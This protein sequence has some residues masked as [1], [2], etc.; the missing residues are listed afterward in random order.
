MTCP[1]CGGTFTKRLTV[2]ER[3]DVMEMYYHGGRHPRGPSQKIFPAWSPADRELF[4]MS[5]LCD[6]CWKRIFGDPDLDDVGVSGDT[7]PGTR[8]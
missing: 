4:L 7:D 6:S 1:Q 5:H 3:K 8:P 2:Q